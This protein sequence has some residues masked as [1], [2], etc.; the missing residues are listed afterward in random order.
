MLRYNILLSNS[1]CHRDS[2]SL[3]KIILPAERQIPMEAKSKV[4]II[5]GTGYFGKYMVE[6][7][8]K[9]GHPTF[10]FVRES[11]L[12]NPSKTKII[13][14]FVAL[15]ISF[16]FV[17]KHLQVSY[18]FNVIWNQVLMVEVIMWVLVTPLKSQLLNKKFGIQITIK[19]NCCLG[20]MI[21]SNYNG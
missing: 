10:A 9:S 16:L 19:T 11:T 3:C 12:C 4:L 13:H 7:S 15:G 18:L 1:N 6:A 17:R 14:K 21:K 8:A 2:L 20:L 5:G